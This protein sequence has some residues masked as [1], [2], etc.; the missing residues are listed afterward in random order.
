MLRPDGFQKA[1][2][3]GL[4]V[5]LLFCMICIAVQPS[6]ETNAHVSVCFSL[7]SGLSVIFSFRRNSMALRNGL[8][9]FFNTLQ[10]DRRSPEEQRATRTNNY[11]SLESIIHRHVRKTTLVIQ[12]NNEEPEKPL[13]PYTHKWME[14][15]CVCV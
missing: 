10:S 13:H 1:S 9:Q 8:N 4:L 14:W 5:K 15:M 12:E 11:K 2:L 7:S 3:T 6:G